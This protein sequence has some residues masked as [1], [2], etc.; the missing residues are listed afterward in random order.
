MS[1]RER[2]EAKAEAL[3]SLKRH[4]L[5]LKVAGNVVYLPD[6]YE[7]YALL[8]RET[9]EG[10]RIAEAKLEQIWRDSMWWER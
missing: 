3:A 6:G 2:T 8:I 5:C 10:Y 1:V 4:C 7:Y 9:A